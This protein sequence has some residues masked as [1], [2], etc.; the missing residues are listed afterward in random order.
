MPKRCYV[1]TKALAVKDNRL[2]RLGLRPNGRSNKPSFL[3]L[4]PK[5]YIFPSCPLPPSD[6]KPA[7]SPLGICSLRSLWSLQSQTPFRL[8]P[9]GGRGRLF[10]KRTKLLHFVTQFFQIINAALFCAA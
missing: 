2:W 6:P 1:Q 5:R 9:D 10:S 3:R 8:T 4:I 7:R